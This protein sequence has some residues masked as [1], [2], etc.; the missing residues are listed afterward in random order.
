VVS[1]VSFSMAVKG[2]GQ[3]LSFSMAGKGRGKKNP[4][5]T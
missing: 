2:R 1:K 3:K 4:V 5:S